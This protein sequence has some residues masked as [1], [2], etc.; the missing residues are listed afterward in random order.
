MTSSPEGRQEA[1]VSVKRLEWN[2]P[3]TLA[4]GQTVWA[5]IAEGMEFTYSIW[6]TS[7]PSDTRRFYCAKVL[8]QLF[9]SL[10]EAKDAVQQNYDDR[11]LGAIVAKFNGTFQ[12]HVGHSLANDTWFV[13]SYPFASEI[14]AKTFEAR[15]RSALIPAKPAV[16]VVEDDA[17]LYDDNATMADGEVRMTAAE[18]VLAWLLIEKIGVPDDEPI[19]PKR[20][21]DTIA[22]VI[23]RFHEY[24]EAAALQAPT[25]TK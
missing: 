5:A 4:D 8:P 21:Q 11:I 2:D 10:E 22:Y 9:D 7:D 16:E 15:I 1:A 23:D 6:T 17:R 18:D 25:V 3:N 13:R 12:S 19:T 20:A 14:D 24:E